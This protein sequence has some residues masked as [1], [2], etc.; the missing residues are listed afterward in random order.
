MWRDEVIGGNLVYAARRDLGARARSRTP[1]GRLPDPEDADYWEQT[2]V[3]D[4]MHREDQRDRIRSSAQP[5]AAH[6]VHIPQLAPLA[7]GPVVAAPTGKSPPQGL[8]AHMLAA[9]IDQSAAELAAQKAA[10]HT[11]CTT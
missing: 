2:S 5:T 11:S 1:V 8:P 7:R 6:I 9:A 10:A 3:L 4:E